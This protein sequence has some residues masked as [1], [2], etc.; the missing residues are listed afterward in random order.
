[1]PVDGYMPDVASCLRISQR[2]SSV[3]IYC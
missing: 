2:Y 1:M 3:E